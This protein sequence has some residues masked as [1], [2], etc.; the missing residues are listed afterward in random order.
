MVYGLIRKGEIRR[1]MMISSWKSV[2]IVVA[3]SLPRTKLLFAG[4]VCLTSRPPFSIFY[5]YFYPLWSVIR[6]LMYR[7][8]SSLPC[9]SRP[10][11]APL[12]FSSSLRLSRSASALFGHARSTLPLCFARSCYEPVQRHS[13]GTHRSLPWLPIWFPKGKTRQSR[14]Y[15]LPVSH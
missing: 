5:F 3:C 10:L 12:S 4:P 7:Y 14:I 1:R 11:L 13:G 8:S 9:C 2:S 6:S 15:T